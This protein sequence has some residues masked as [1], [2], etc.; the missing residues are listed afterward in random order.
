MV[1]LAERGLLPSAIKC[2][3]KAPSCAAC[4][5]AKVQRQAWRN[6]GKRSSPIQKAHHTTPGK[7]TSANHIILHQLGLIPHVTGTLTHQRYWGA[8]T[9]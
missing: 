5:F 4:L 9:M 2:V 1:E 6:K 3:K 7:G 8:V